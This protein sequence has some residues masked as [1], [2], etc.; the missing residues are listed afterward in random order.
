VGNFR[1]AAR[2]VSSCCSTH[3]R[4]CPTQLKT[5]LNRVHPIQP[6]VYTDVVL[7]GLQVVVGVRARR[8]ARGHCSGCGCRRRTHD[9][10]TTPRRFEFVPLWGLAAVLMYYMRRLDCPRCGVTVEMVPWAEGK[11]RTC[12]AYRVFLSAWARRM[13]W[14][15]VSTTFHTSWGVVYRAVQWVVA[16]GLAH[17]SL[18]GVRAIGV[19]EIAVWTGH[20]YLTVVY[21]IDAAQRRLLWVGRERT[22][23]TFRD[24]FA[25]FG[26]ERAKALR[27]VVSDMWRPFLKVIAE[28]ASGAIHVL[29]RYHVVAN[30]NKAIDKIRAT[31]AR[32]LAKRGFDVL[33]NT[34]WAFLKRAENRTPTQQKRLD[35]V[36]HYDLKTVRAHLHKEAFEAFW[37]YRSPCWAGWFLDGWTRRVMR[38]RLD[39]LKRFARSLRKHRELLLNWFRARDQISLGVVEGMNLN[40]KFAL[41]KARGFRTEDAL[42]TALYHQLGKLPEP[43]LAHRLW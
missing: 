34:R 27:F 39:P 20:K 1:T 17:R 11:E 26:D 21:Q 10:A 8:G 25:M 19:D 7:D 42:T 6:F 23:K 37:T 32:A 43:K 13:S 2:R 15:E 22:E 24:F 33:K 12:N 30:L 4:R 3:T 35:D 28:K 29:D 36:L 38:S 31:E 5:I 9:T 41:R 16:Y 40:A 14:S 18:D